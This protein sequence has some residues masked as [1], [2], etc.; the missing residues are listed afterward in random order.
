MSQPVC[1]ADID[2][3]FRQRA[4]LFSLVQAVLLLPHF[5]D[6]LAPFSGRAVGPPQIGRA[7]CAVTGRRRAHPPGCP[8]PCL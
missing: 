3:L 2:P 4:V 8:K 5:V 7:F 6:D 1:W